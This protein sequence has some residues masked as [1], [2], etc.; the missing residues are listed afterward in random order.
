MKAILNNIKD[1]LTEDFELSVM[2]TLCACG[3][4]GIT[5]FAIYRFAQGDWLSGAVD[6][7]ILM[8]IVAAFTYA[9]KTGD[10]LNG[11]R[12]LGVII[13]AGGVAVGSILG[14]NGAFWLYPASLTSYF[15]CPYRFAACINLLALLILSTVGSAFDS[16]E[17]MLSFVATSLVV[18]ACAFIFAI[19]HHSQ[20]RKLQQ[21]ASHD[22]LTGARNRRAL[23][24][25]L[26]NAVSNA[27]RTG[28]SYALVMLDLDHFKR[29]NDDYGHHAGDEVLRECAD[30]LRHHIRESDQLFRYGGEEFTLLMTGVSDKGLHAVVDKLRQALQTHLSSP[31]G[32]VTASFGVALLRPDE[33]WEAWVARADNALYLAKEGGR[34]RVVVELEVEA[35]RA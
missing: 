12:C 10:T 6:L 13:C 2:T 18:N 9:W 16:H 7:V 4:F 19:R 30:I 31:G 11:G 29:I 1:R 24:T 5:P 23:A 26:E 32:P 34:N 3:V 21:L 15:L 8:S 28:L 25:D 33:H 14:I 27:R 22:P 35:A 20:H 17:Q